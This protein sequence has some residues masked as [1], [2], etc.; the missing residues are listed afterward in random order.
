MFKGIKILN[1]FLGTMYT[2]QNKKYDSG[3]C[4]ML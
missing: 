1:V 2:S 3:Q 4:E